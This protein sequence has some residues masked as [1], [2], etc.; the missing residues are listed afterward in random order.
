MK[1][2]QQ[3]NQK[4]FFDA[5]ETLSLKEKEEN[6]TSGDISSEPIV[7]S[8]ARTE[9]ILLEKGKAEPQHIPEDSSK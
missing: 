1:K 6:E 4:L 8:S 5:Q 2:V 3:K 7:S 9:L